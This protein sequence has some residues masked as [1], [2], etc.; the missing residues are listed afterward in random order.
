VTR[1]RCVVCGKLTSGRLPRAPREPGDGSF[2]FPRR[3]R[4]KDGG[5]KMCPGTL[6][7]AE[8]VTIETVV[9]PCP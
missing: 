1:F 7:E 8:R 5:G 3:H 4:M 2:R 6:Q 9:K